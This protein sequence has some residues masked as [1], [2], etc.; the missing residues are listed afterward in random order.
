MKIILINIVLL[1]LILVS[2]CTP[3]VRVIDGDTILITGNEMVR[4]IG[5]DTPERGEPYYDEAKMANSSLLSWKSISLE[6]DLN[7]RD[8]HGRLLRYVFAND[9]LVNA[10]LVRKGY[11]MVYRR[12][13]FPEQKYYQ[14]LQN[15]ADEAVLNRR[16][17]WGMNQLH[18][19]LQYREDYYIPN[20][21]LDNLGVLLDIVG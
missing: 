9:V 16:G 6:S 7:D 5:I 11:A 4:Y 10:E 17:I 19:K 3:V 2:G 21:Y 13:L 18:P 12:G 1:M 20:N 15:A 8:K 14:I